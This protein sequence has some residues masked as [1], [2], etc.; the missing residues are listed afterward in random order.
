MTEEKP[1]VILHFA[2]ESHVDRSILSPS[3]SFETPA[4]D[5]TSSASGLSTPA[6][7]SEAEPI[8]RRSNT[9]A[10]PSAVN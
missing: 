6:N 1:D 9:A 5:S 10:A 4:R 7:S 2:A 3:P 8:H